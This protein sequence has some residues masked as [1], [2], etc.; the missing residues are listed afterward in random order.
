MCVE[1]G[2][3]LRKDSE[4]SCSLRAGYEMCLAE[5]QIRNP[6]VSGVLTMHLDFD[7]WKNPQVGKIERSL[8]ESIVVEEQ[9]KQEL[10]G[11]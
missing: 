2:V 5:G 11:S 7:C 9:P 4:H 10:V 6:T 3:V 1:E 8:G